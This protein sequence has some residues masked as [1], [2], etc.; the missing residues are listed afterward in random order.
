MPWQCLNEMP[1]RVT[2]PVGAE[3]R[4]FRGE[5]DFMIPFSG[6]PQTVPFSWRLPMMLQ[7]HL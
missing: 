2:V 7:V 4:E 6:G 1:F 5:R 3:R